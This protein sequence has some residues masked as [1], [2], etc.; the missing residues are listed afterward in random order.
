[1]RMP[2]RENTFQAYHRDCIML[3]RSCFLSTA[4]DHQEDT[5]YT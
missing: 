5:H 4:C 3:A 1:M 2:S